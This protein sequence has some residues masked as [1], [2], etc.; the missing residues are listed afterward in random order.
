MGCGTD[1]VGAAYSSS[2]YHLDYFGM[3]VE[4]EDRVHGH[5]ADEDPEH[6]VF[7]VFAVSAAAGLFLAG[8]ISRL[9]RVATYR[10]GV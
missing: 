2:S 10:D 6:K 7:S 5:H 4:M 9:D 8:K 3:Q 1:R